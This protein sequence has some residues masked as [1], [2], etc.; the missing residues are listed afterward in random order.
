MPWRICYFHGKINCVG[1][2]LA[3]NTCVAP[4]TALRWVYDRAHNVCMII[5]ML[6]VLIY[7]FLKPDLSILPPKTDRC[8]T[9]CCIIS[10]C[11]IIK[12]KDLSFFSLFT[13]F[14]WHVPWPLTD[15]I[16]TKLRNLSLKYENVMEIGCLAGQ[17]AQEWRARSQRRW[18]VGALSLSLP[19][20]GLTLAS[21]VAWK[22]QAW[23][24]TSLIIQRTTG[25]DPIC[26]QGSHTRFIS[27]S[28]L[29]HHA[30]LF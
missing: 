27:L 26:T 16:I 18:T 14:E 5:V 1:L 19:H 24:A 9:T 7:Y 25:F 17:T 22:G 10:I 21:P 11:W 3:K 2:K 29:F 23:N 12:S 15:T 6:C 13:S 4:G 8:T 28:L 20:L 30:L